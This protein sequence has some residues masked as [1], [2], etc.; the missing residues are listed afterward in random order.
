MK[1]IKI[2]VT[3]D[4]QAAEKFVGRCRQILTRGEL[5]ILGAYVQKELE[6]GRNLDFRS[7]GNPQL[8]GILLK[9]LADERAFELLDKFRKRIIEGRAHIERKAAGLKPGKYDI[10]K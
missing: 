3:K 2:F 6:A 7:T 1:Q 10:V 5:R 8:D 9:V 4:K